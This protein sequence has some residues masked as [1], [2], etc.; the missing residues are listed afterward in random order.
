MNKWKNLSAKNWLNEQTMESSHG[1]TVEI[2]NDILSIYLFKAIDNTCFYSHCHC[3]CEPGHAVCGDGV[4]LEG[5]F[6]AFLPDPIRRL[7]RPRIHNPWRQ[8]YSLDTRAPWEREGASI[9]GYC[10]IVRQIAPFN[11]LRMLISLIELHIFD[12][13][14][15]RWWLVVGNCNRYFSNM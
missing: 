13:I 12:F 11:K 5:S 8:S 10:K 14:I 4:K 3:L 15:D 1:L 9:D 2:S 6:A 7:K